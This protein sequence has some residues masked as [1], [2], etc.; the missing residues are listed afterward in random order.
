[1]DFQ[2]SGKA[3]LIIAGTRGLGRA[4]AT[5]LVSEGVRVAITGRNVAQGEATAR[6]LGNGTCFFAGD[7]TSGA[8]RQ[9]VLEAVIDRF[10][11][12]AIVVVNGPGPT[13]DAFL[14]TP[15]Q[16][17]DE[18]FQFM[19][20]P[21]LD[22]VQ[23]CI[24]AMVDRKWGRVINLS[25]ISGKEISLLGC[26]ANGLRPALAGALGTLAREVAA[27]GV[28]INSIL[29]GPFDTPAMRTVVRQ[30]AGRMDL[31]EGEAV[32]SYAASG[33]MKRLGNVAE[34]GALCAFL[35]SA[36]AGY[37][38]GQAIAID[39]GRVASLY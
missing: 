17:W 3:A 15:I 26:R 24:P 13:A 25:S 33:P 5:A 7:I 23:R 36:P 39:G 27:D 6:E 21:A 31:T 8:D 29:S 22:I 19:V 4:C 37:I 2:I 32:A 12:P 20:I 30:H 11:H 1:M 14:E 38:T 28:T 16:A 9:Q 35:A 10:G 34:L 18:A